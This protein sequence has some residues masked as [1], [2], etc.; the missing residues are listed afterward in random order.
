MIERFAEYDQRP[1]LALANTT[2]T[3]SELVKSI[4]A[5]RARFVQRGIQSGDVVTLEA[6][7][8]IS[9]IAAL[10]AL[11]ELKTVVA[12]ITSVSDSELEF[13]RSEVNA[14]W[15][16]R[17]TSGSV[18]PEVIAQETVATACEII[19][20]LKA[21]GSSG[22]VLFSSGSTGRPKAMVHGVDRLLNAFAK[23]SSR[24]RSILILLLFD[25]IGGLNTLFNALAS[26]SLVV[27][28]VSR[29]VDAVSGAIQNHRVNLLPASPTFLNLLLIHHAPEKFDLSSL[30]FVTYGTEPMPES[31]LLRLKEALPHAS[32][33]QTFGTS[34]TGIS[35]TLSR[36]SKSTRIKINDPNTEFKVVNGELW[37]RSK[38]QIL[39]YLNHDMSRFTEDGWFKTGDMVEQF[40]DGFLKIM[41]RRKDVINVGGEKVSPLEVESVLMELAE[42]SDCHVYSEPNAIT[43]QIVAARIILRAD[44][45]N[46]LKYFRRKIKQYCR[47]RL[48]PY[49]VPARITFDQK[50]NFTKRYK[51]SRE[52]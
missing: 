2:H 49:K 41:G 5:H 10:F 17:V 43:G 1:C 23:K 7:Y 30:R 34:E 47:E 51:K 6:D 19:E 35:Q 16:V 33:I 24:K 15:N 44:L 12:P 52:A 29:D 31:L 27:V 14:R 11:F 32:F 45:G 48:S 25:H 38:T 3:Y 36:S 9:A 40:P 50:V 21:D 39:G 42:V 22:L 13:R 8:S 20:Q 26:G 46:D 28:P 37:L 4:H 18:F